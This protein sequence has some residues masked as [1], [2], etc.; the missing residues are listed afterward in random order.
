MFVPAVL[1]LFKGCRGI[2]AIAIVVAELNGR[3]KGQGPFALKLAHKHQSPSAQQASARG[4]EL[5]RC[6]VQQKRFCC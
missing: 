1:Q 5:L 3:F 2:A 6:G 4:T